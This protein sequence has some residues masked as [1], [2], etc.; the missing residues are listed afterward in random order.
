[1]SI[2]TKL[3]AKEISQ[4]GREI[5]DREIRAKVEKDH[6]GQFIVVDILT[7]NYE[8][9]EDDAAATSCALKKNPAALLWGIRIGAPA[10]YRIGWHGTR[11]GTT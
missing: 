1:M 3:S 4:R 5:Y 2:Q 7:G 8:I 9:G 11:I 6:D 10:A